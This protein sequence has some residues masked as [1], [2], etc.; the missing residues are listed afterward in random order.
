MNYKETLLEALLF[1]GQQR[2][3]DSSRLASLSGFSSDFDRSGERT[4]VTN[5]QME[6][7]WS[8]MVEYSNNK[9]IG[10][11]F[12]ETMQVAAFRVIGQIIQTSNTVKDALEQACALVPLLTDL[13][14]M[15][16]EQN[17]KTFTITFIPN[18]N[19]DDFPV[20]REQMGDFLVAFTLHE[21]KGLIMDKARPI[22]VDLP[23]YKA[24]YDR[25]YDS[26]LKCRPRAGEYYRLEFETTYLHAKIIS[27]DHE[28]RE[29][30]LSQLER[31]E[32][33]ARF[34]GHF[35]KRIFN[36][37]IANSYLYSLSIEA[38]ADNFNVTVRTLQRK[39]KEEGI[40]YI[41]II[42]E[43][44]R[45][46]AVDYIKNT[47]APIKE[48]SVVLGYAESSGFVR[49]FKK[50]TGKTPSEYRELNKVE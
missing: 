11:H 4:P 6:S 21:L 17:K 47:D 44:R 33:S 31:K 35:S 16:M 46:L 39:L 24:D 49:A 23:S 18:K 45:A 50:W 29:L 19:T 25:L 10:M 38:V 37:L 15:R 30:L 1:F 5:R 9:L 43:V 42:Q 22:T 2:G 26:I 20:S 8:N 32:N 40:S 27:A 48:I 13:Y 28:I 41:R 36:F 3:L 34:E 7:L 12:G 14:S